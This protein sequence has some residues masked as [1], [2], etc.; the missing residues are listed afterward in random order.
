MADWLS[1]HNHLKNKNK[2]ITCIQISINA[3]QSTINLPE[4]MKICQLQEAT[5]QDQH[6]QHLIEYVIQEWPESK[7]QLL[8][9]IRTYLMFR[10]NMTVIDGIV[11][12]GTHIV[13]P[14]A[15][16]LKM[17]KQLHINHM[18]I[19]NTKLLVHKSIYWIGMNADIENHIKL[20]YMP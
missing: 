13:M 5:S 6:L 19:E 14:E 9:D 1:R 8:Q 11:I 4:C 10:D 15:L 20:F 12:K 17:L 18:D 16:H 3:T 2:E 7:N